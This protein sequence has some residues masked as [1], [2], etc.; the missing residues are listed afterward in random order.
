MGRE[1]EGKRKGREWEQMWVRV[2]VE[3]A[4][5][6]CEFCEAEENLITTYVYFVRFL[7][8]A[9]IFFSNPKSQAMHD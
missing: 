4:I 9:T 6:M 5:V 7:I 1:R 8:W 2:I 3:E